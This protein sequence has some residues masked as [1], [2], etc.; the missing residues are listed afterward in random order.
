MIIRALAE[1]TAEN[2]AQAPGQQHIMKQ[3]HVSLHVASAGLSLYV[4]GFA[5]GPL[6]CVY[7]PRIRIRTAI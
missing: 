7:F 3:Y 4:L 1:P 6:I 5:A 2:G